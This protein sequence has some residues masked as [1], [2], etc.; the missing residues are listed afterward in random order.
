[1]ERKSLSQLLADMRKIW[2]E[3]KYTQYQA[4]RE[5]QQGHGSVHQQKVIHCQHLKKKLNFIKHQVL[6]RV[7]QPG[8]RI[9]FRMGN[10]NMEAIFPAL[11]KTDGVTYI[12]LLAMLNNCPMEILE[13]QE[14][15]S[16]IKET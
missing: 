1:M 5:L 13:I 6:Y 2:D 9:K 7:N 4:N 3:Y 12:E 16:E 11:S 15:K 8:V 10:K 14:I